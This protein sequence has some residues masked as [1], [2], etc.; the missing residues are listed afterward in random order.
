MS[1][2]VSSTSVVAALL[3]SIVLWGGNN[4]FIKLLVQQWPPLFTGATR[5]LIGGFLLAGL[6]RWIPALRTAHGTTAAQRRDLWVRGGVVLAL[7]NTACNWCLLYI[8]ASHFAL[9]LAA[10]PV[11]ALLWEE[12]LR[13]R[14]HSL[15]RFAAAGLTLVGVGVLLWPALT[16]SGHW[17]GELL[18]LIAGILWTAYN[19]ECRRMSQGLSGL[20]VTS[21]TVWRAGAIMLLPAA[22]EVALRGPF[23]ITPA[24]LGLQAYSIVAGSVGAYAC[25]NWALTHWPV[26]RVALWGNLIPLTTMG[27]GVLLIGEKLSPSFALALTLILGGVVLGQLRFGSAPATPEA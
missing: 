22:I 23:A 17:F 24:A 2:A 4:V 9:H 25:W 26:S 12:G 5:F 15:P 14:R 6:L 11:W 13:I 20:Q 3:T 1:R 8:P 19:R 10:S 18:A 21:G 16:G 7:Y 27:C